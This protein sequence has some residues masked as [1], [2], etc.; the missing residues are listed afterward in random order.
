MNKSLSHHARKAINHI[1]VNTM[2]HVKWLEIVWKCENKTTGDTSPQGSS[3][4]D[5]SGTP[6]L[7]RIE[8][9]RLP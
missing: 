5:R 7:S 4:N 8:P 9:L 3:Q 6:T 1:T 2:I